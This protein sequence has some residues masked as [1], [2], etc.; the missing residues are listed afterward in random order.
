MSDCCCCCVSGVGL[1]ACLAVWIGI[2]A[3]LGG[4]GVDPDPDRG[5]WIS[6]MGTGNRGIGFGDRWRIWELCGSGSRRLTRCLLVL[7]F[8]A[9]RPG[10]GFFAFDLAGRLLSVGAE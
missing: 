3:R 4:F 10:R 1:S 7:Q 9:A 2:F 6:L 8:C 5:F